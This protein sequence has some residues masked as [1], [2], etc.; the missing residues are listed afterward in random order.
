MTPAPCSSQNASQAVTLFL[1]LSGRRDCWRH[2]STYLVSQSWPH[3]QIRLIC[4]DTSQ[5]PG[6]AREVGQ[7]LLASGYSD[8]TYFA[9]AAGTAGLVNQDRRQQ[10]VEYETNLVMPVTTS[11]AGG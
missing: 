3:D 8:V 11:S 10:G 2:M 6:Y 1:P 4:C 5:D 7:W 9:L